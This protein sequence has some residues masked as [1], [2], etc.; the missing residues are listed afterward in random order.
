[1][2]QQLPDRSGQSKGQ[3]ETA[4]PDIAAVKGKGIGA[5]PS[6]LFP[7]SRKCTSHLGFGLGLPAGGV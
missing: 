6:D 4:L 7:Q 1:M 2:G 5:T 3:G